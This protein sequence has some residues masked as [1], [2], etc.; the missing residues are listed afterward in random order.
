MEQEPFIQHIRAGQASGAPATDSQLR[1]PITRN[2]N[3]IERSCLRCHRR[4]VRC[5]KKSPCASCA[6]LGVSCF[7]PGPDEAFRRPHRVTIS[8]LSERL[9]RLERTVQAMSH[10]YHSHGGNDQSTTTAATSP[11][12]PP[13][14]ELTAQES[15]SNGVLVKGGYSS[16][17]FNETLISRV[18]EEVLS[19]RPF[20]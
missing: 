17:Y 16:R 3:R 5:D 1:R 7:Y 4:K 11:D 18:L 13:A 8:D 15:S 19:M 10:V 9:A 6:R 14:E 12:H 2:S 20:L